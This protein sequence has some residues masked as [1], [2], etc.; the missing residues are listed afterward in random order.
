MNE[1]EIKKLDE[2]GEEEVSG[3]FKISKDKRKKILIQGY[4][5]LDVFRLDLERKK[6]RDK[7][8]EKDKKPEEALKPWH[9]QTEEKK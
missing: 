7:E 9:P 4:G 5:A 2:K 3:G 6:L 8:N 1:K